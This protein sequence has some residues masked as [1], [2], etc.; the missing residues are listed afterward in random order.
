MKAI[1]LWQPWASLIA[2][3]AKKYE[4]RSWYTNYRGPIAIHAAKR[5]FGTGSYL[6]R[7]LYV[8]A[9]ALGLPDIYSFDTLAHGCIVAYAE[10]VGC[11]EMFDDGSGYKHKIFLKRPHYQKEYIQG[12]EFIFGNWSAGRYAWEFSNIQILDIP[13]P[14]KGKQG[15]WNWEEK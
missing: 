11:H 14:A 4:T 12:N 8:F 2:C 7:E 9:D 5:A 1:T 13:I 10:L 15:F 6:D 3:K